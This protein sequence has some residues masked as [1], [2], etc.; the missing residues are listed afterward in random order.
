M[1]MHPLLLPFTPRF[2]VLTLC[3]AATALLGGLLYLHPSTL[4]GAA[5]PLALF[6]G[7]SALGVRDLFQTRHAVLRNYPIAAHLR[8][9]LEDVRPELRQY[10]FEG[11]KDGAPFSRDKRA[12]VYQRAMRALDKRPFGTE[13]NVYQEG[14]EWV[15]HSMAPRPLATAP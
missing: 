13:Y 14:Y 6:G 9:L 5:I 4:Y 10:F 12:L 1:S 15:R 7:L 3:V 11:E 2:I 8:F